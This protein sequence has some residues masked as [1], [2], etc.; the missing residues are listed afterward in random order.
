VA[1]TS[2]P[3]NAAHV[4]GNIGFCL[5]LGPT[6]V[7]ALARYRRRFEVRWAGSAAAVLVACSLAGMAAPPGAQAASP[8]ARAVAYLRAAQ[9]P[10]GGF[11]GSR[12][13]SSTSLHTGWTALGLAAAGV[14]AADVSAA[15]G[16]SILDY[17][18][19]QAGGLTDIGELE[20]TVLAVDAAGVSAR[21][22]AGRDLV[23]A[24]ERQRSRNGS[25]KSNNGWTAF[26]VLALKASGGSG[27]GRS[28]RWLA[29]QQNSDGGFGFRPH[30]ISDV[31]DTG[32]VLQGLAA[33]G[34]RGSKP[35]RRAV[36]FL[37]GA[38][39][40]DGGFAQMRGGSSNAQSTSWAVQGLVAA[41]RN[42]G[43]FRRAG[44]SPLSYLR[45]LQGGDGSIRYSRVSAQTPVWVT[46]QA[47]DALEQK[48]FPL[49]A[50]ARAARTPR[51]SGP[52]GGGGAGGAAPGG[53]GAGGS[54]GGGAGPGG[55]GA[56]GSPAS[57]RKKGG[58]GGAGPKAPAG[59]PGAAAAPPA[60]PVSGQ[61]ATATPRP[62][63]AP[64]ARAFAER[65]AARAMSRFRGGDSG[66]AWAAGALVAGVAALALWQLATRRRP[67]VV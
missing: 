50:A 64:P 32:A 67:P 34:L 26:G 16:A 23:A 42:P 25:W 55:A 66:G 3:Y 19:A 10:D 36:A 15:G 13:Q 35:V 44:R 39:N 6:F 43:S 28:A 60:P 56:G 63:G 47:L 54:G 65:V 8:A 2:L 4:V 40:V 21:S 1:T 41:G 17:L 18:R 22:F 31:D 30:A 12:G 57:P 59:A 14:N 62:S 58:S 20:R 38:Q 9:N 49:A 46:A 52:R 53:G 27:L 48:A 33:G 51:R 7:R 37:R 61:P 45:S 11:G 24:I 29:G 5:L